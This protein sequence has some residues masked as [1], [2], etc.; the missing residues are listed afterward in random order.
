[1]AFIVGNQSFVTE[2][3]GTVEMIDVGD[4]AAANPI[5]YLCP[6]DW[7]YL[8]VAITFRLV[9]DATVIDRFVYIYMRETAAGSLLNS[10]VAATAVVASATAIYSTCWFYPNDVVSNSRHHITLPLAYLPPAGQLEIGALNLQAADQLDLCR[11]T[12]QKWRV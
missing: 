10:V 11:L 9:A 4:P 12:V 8:P 1:M 5:L 2:G 6:V 7:V 3:R